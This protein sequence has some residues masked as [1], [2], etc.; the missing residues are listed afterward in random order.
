MCTYV[1]VEVL[2]TAPGSGLRCDECGQ[3][4]T[5][6]QVECRAGGTRLHQWCHYARLQ[7]ADRQSAALKQE[8][9]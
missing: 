2:T 6:S 4:I 1:R 8:V 5:T 7:G 3:P 9:A